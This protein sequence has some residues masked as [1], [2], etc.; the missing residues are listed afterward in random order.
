MICLSLLAL[1]TMFAGQNNAQTAGTIVIYREP[2]SLHYAGGVHATV[3][4]DGIKVAKMREGHR[5][6]ISARVG[7]HTCVAVEKQGDAN[8]DSDS[9]SVDVKPNSTIYLRLQYPFGRA[10]FVLREVSKET[11]AAESAKT[12]LVKTGDSYTM[13]LPVIPKSSSP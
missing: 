9:V 12:Q 1:L 11:G 2:G 10:H 3:Y 6:E 13:V 7:P 5:A 8:E 4:C